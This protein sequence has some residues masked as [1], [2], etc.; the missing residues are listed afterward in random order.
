MLLYNPRI[1]KN[2]SSGV[3]ISFFII[4]Q[5]IS[6]GNASNF[7]GQT[8]A[9]FYPC[10]FGNQIPPFSSMIFPAINL[11]WVWGL[12]IFFTHLSHYFSNFSHIFLIFC[13][14]SHI[15]PWFSHCSKGVSPATTAPPR[16]RG[17]Q[18]FQLP[19]PG[20]HGRHKGPVPKELSG[21]GSN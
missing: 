9:N 3:A 16:P 20:C 13:Q 18:G 6:D 7:T 1:G 8:Q 10:W 11:H 21:R 17:L 15:F 2:N 4:K 12:P 14:V 19:R 5:C